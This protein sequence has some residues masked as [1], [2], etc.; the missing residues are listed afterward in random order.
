MTI[1][2][3]IQRLGF[4]EDRPVLWLAT[5]DGLISG[6][7]K[8]LINPNE[9][10]FHPQVIKNF[11]G[12]VCFPGTAYNNEEAMSQTSTIVNLTASTTN[13]DSALEKVQ[14]CSVERALHA[15][16]DAVAVHLNIS[17]DHESKQLKTMGRVIDEAVKLGVPTVAIAY[18]RRNSYQ[19]EDGVDNYEEMRKT[20]IAGY[21]KLV[22]HTVRIAVEMGA[23]VVKT[24]FTGSTETFCEV[25]DAAMGIPVLIAGGPLR[26]NSEAIFRA[27]QAVAAGGSGVCYG[28]QIFENDDPVDFIVALRNSM[29]PGLAVPMPSGF[30]AVGADDGKPAN[31]AE[32]ATQTVQ[33]F[34]AAVTT[35]KAASG[36]RYGVT[37][38]HEEE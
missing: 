35:P 21:T 29:L 8:H 20:D 19:T 5:D 32:V 22:A 18:P 28:R 23:D 25:V 30:L 11:D 4:G 37:Q 33:R 16:A 26:P 9:V 34:T 27:N 7:T 24:V 1:Y 17:S 31:F 6:P 13:W 3:R 38:F 36:G 14:I 2:K 15:G 10:L 12:V